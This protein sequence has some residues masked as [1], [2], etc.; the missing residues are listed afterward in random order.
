MEDRLKL[1]DTLKMLDISRFDGKI[2]DVIQMLANERENAIAEGYINIRIDVYQYYENNDVCIRADRYEDDKE[3]AD[4]LKRE[5]KLKK[6]AKLDKKKR[7]EAER[8]LY[9]KLKKK[10]EG[11]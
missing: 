3:Y 1:T 4:R 10:Y 8:K 11:E 7:D 2:D 6:R 9:E 5:K